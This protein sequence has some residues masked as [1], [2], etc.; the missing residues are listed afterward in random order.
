MPWDA[1]LHCALITANH[2]ASKL[3]AH[4]DA[5]IEESRQ[6]SLPSCKKLGCGLPASTATLSAALSST[7]FHCYPAFKFV[8]NV[9]EFYFKTFALFCMMSDVLY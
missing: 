1:E 2:R 7:A 3:T 5:N 9:I 8:N 4:T 6:Q